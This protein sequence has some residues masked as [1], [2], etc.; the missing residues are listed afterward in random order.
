MTA[1]AHSYFAIFFYMASTTTQWLRMR[2]AALP[3]LLV[4]ILTLAGTA[5]QFFSIHDLICTTEGF[6]LSFSTVGSLSTWMVILIVLVS[7]LRK[8]VE[9][10]LVILLPM[11]S[12]AIISSAFFHIP[13]SLL[14]NSQP[15]MLGHVVISVLAYSTLTVAAVQALLLAYQEHHLKRHAPIGLAKAFPPM[16]TMERLLFEFV[17]TGLCLLTLALA[18]GFIYLHDM[19]EQNVVHKTLLGITAWI[20][21]AVLFIGRV[22]HG[23]RGRTAIVW[24]LSGFVALML[25]YFGS[26]IVIDLILN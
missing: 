7:S 24:T 3:K 13:V 8:P 20:L 17:G 22:K 21:F 2:G 23:W 15:G 18:S 14:K 16:Q 11:G 26:K 25:A 5:T 1:E 9:N 4:Q 12:V 19:F 6:N 10:L